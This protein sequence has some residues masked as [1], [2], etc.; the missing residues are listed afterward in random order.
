MRVATFYDLPGIPVEG[1]D[2]D[3]V[4]VASSQLSE[5]IS[6]IE[7]LNFGNVVHSRSIL[8][9]VMLF[10]ML[11]ML[12]GI[13]FV[14]DPSAKKTQASI[15]AL[16]QSWKN[17]DLRDPIDAALSIAEMQA[18]SREFSPAL[19]LVP[20]IVPMVGL[21][22]FLLVSLALTKYAFPPYNFAWGEYLHE[23][24]KKKGRRRF[25][26]IGIALTIALGVLANLLSKKLGL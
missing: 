9:L 8:L 6:R 26:F 20:M 13:S 10:S 23:Y 19:V 18:T 16:R 14:K 2:R 22:L 7:R 24:E 15:K 4:F 11:G 5:R 1:E 25:V 12:A 3:W 17:G 21:P